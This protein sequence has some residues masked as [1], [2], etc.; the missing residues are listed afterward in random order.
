[1]FDCHMTFTCATNLHKRSRKPCKRPLPLPYIVCNDMADSAEK[2]NKLEQDVKTYCEVLASCNLPEVEN[3]KDEDLERVFRWS[4]YFQ[5]VRII[6]YIL[7][8]TT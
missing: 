1:M 8:L 5:Q 3:W 4:A 7:N 6:W 2:S